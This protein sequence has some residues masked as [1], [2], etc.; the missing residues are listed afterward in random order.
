[1]GNKCKPDIGERVEVVTVQ[2]PHAWGDKCKPDS[3]E[4]VEVVSVQGPYAWGD[5]CEPTLMRVQR[6][7]ATNVI[8]WHNQLARTGVSIN[9][10]LLNWIQTYKRFERTLFIATK[11]N[12]RMI[13]IIPFIMLQNDT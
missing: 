7:Q 11:H 3:G 4:G 2:G 6:L 9:A 10:L 12:T 5:K 1:M 8:N 13:G